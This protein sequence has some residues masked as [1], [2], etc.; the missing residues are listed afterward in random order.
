MLR[1]LTLPVARISDFDQLPT[2]FRAVAPTSR[3][4]DGGHGSAI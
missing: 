4:R 2:P 3:A 1:R